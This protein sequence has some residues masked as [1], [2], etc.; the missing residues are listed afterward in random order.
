M[1]WRNRENAFHK[2]GRFDYGTERKESF[3]GIRRQARLEP[4]AGQQRTHFGGKQ[5]SAAGGRVIEG[6]NSQPVP[7]KKNARV[8]RRFSRSARGTRI[9][10]GNGK[11][12]AKFAQT[13]LAP[14]LIGVDNDLRI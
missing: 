4:A 14:F 3:Q 11:H 12:P 5:E 6:L 10:D 2:R 13:L 7:R 1:S 9:P 8:P